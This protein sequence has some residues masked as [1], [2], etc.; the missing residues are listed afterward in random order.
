ML[1]FNEIAWVPKE[2]KQDDF[3]MTDINYK[4]LGLFLKNMMEV[5]NSWKK[6]VGF[7]RS[8]RG[9]II[10]EKTDKHLAMEK[11]DVLKELE[12][13][14]GNFYGPIII[15]LFTGEVITGEEMN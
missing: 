11:A 7:F 2:V 15:K 14:L 1:T 8:N 10:L 9:H 4:I 5:E 3:I 6:V 12:E 13:M